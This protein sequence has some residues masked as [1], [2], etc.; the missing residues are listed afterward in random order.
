MP[1]ATYGTE[2]QERSEEDVK[3]KNMTFFQLVFGNSVEERDTV[4]IKAQGT[5]AALAWDEYGTIVVPRIGADPPVKRL[6]RSHH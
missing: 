5:S 2:G 1:S 3:T 4:S 6:N